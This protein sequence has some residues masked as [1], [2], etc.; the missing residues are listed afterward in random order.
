MRFVSKHHLFS[1]AKLVF[2]A[3]VIYY[4]VSTDKLDLKHISQI[5]HKKAMIAEVVATILATYALVTIR[6]YY[7]L[8]WQGIPVNFG[9]VIRINCIGLFFNSFMPG[10]FGGDLVKAY[11]IA[12]ENQDYRAKAVITIIIDRIIGL[13]TM[14]IVALC[15]LLLNY[16]TIAGSHQLKALAVAIILYISCSLFAAAA[17]FSKR[18]KRFYIL[19]G[20]KDLLYKLPFKENLLT[21]YDAFHTYADQKKRLVKAM[22]ITIPLDILVIY[23]FYV[24][25]REMGETLV[26]LPSYF[27]AVPA[28][29]VVLS[30]PISPAGIGVGQGAFYNLFKWFGAESG[31]MG[32]T[33]ITVFQLLTIAVN[34]SFVM[35]YLKN[36][37]AVEKAATDARGNT[38]V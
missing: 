29:I 19:I 22:A 26:S 6:W 30:L 35:V 18:V 5:A 34:L 1:F 17:V 2:A 32:A 11:Y 31:A 8:R 15:A 27:T 13:E 25:G 9:D 37:A 33:V 36:K 4:M 3:L 38:Q 28:G 24:I 20:I 7:L 14:M 23:A 12:R 10:A 16:G 21:I